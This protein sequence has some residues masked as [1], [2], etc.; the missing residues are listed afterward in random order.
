MLKL[1]ELSD[2]IR[3][4]RRARIREIQYER[5]DLDHGRRAPER[6]PDR[7]YEREVYYDR[8]GNYYR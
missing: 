4:D 2:D 6:K 5:E 7:V 1:V 8:R 3:K